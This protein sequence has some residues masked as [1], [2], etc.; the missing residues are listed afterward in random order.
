MRV[1]YKGIQSDPVVLNVAQAAP[2]IYTQ[3][4]QGFG[5][6]SILNQDYSVNSTGVPAAMGSVVQVF[7]TGEG[8]TIPTPPNGSVAPA[9]GAG[10]YKPGLPVTATVG[11]IP[12]NVQYYGSAPALIY[13]VM[14]VN[15]EI[16]AGVPSGTVEIVIK[17]GTFATQS[18]VTVAIQ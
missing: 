13:G 14:Q 17:V 11:G 12:A 7:M 15:V 8:L 10:L 1:I 6:G 9:N 16:P 2:A 18:G 3:N 5:P 4:S